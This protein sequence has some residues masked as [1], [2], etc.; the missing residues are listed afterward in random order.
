MFRRSK[1]QLAMVHAIN[2]CKAAMVGDNG[3][4]VVDHSQPGL[5]VVLGNPCLIKPLENFAKEIVWYAIH[6]KLFY[7]HTE[8]KS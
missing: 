1:S 6:K 3:P 5:A 4:S 8:G 7:D 2:P